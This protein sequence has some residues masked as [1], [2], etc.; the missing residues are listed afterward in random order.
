MRNPP[1]VP[2]LLGHGGPLHQVK[3]EDAGFA[4]LE[5]GYWRS[6][7]QVR[8]SW[9][10]SAAS[11]AGC[12]RGGSAPRTRASTPLTEMRIPTAS[13]VVA[14]SPRNITANRIESIGIPGTTS[15]VVHANESR[16]MAPNQVSALRK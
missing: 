5:R 11:E 2:H 9:I 15:A 16:L 12:L 8:G 13:R 6:G 10:A 14:C 7:N 1:W 4:L 3:R